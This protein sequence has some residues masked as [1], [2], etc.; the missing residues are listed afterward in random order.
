MCVC[1]IWEN[2]AD[3]RWSTS[4]QSPEHSTDHRNGIHPQ[5]NI[6]HHPRLSS[7][8]KLDFSQRIEE[9]YGF[10]IRIQLEVSASWAGTTKATS[11]ELVWKGKDRKESFTKLCFSHLNQYWLTVYWIACCSLGTNVKER[12][13]SQKLRATAA[14]TISR[15]TFLFNLTFP[16]YNYLNYLPSCNVYRIAS[17]QP[18]EWRRC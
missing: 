18:Y 15:K 9:R 7:K 2:Q 10:L 11:F 1:L 13:L 12:K 16:T 4:C 17:K 3:W 8:E 6:Q 14:G 5:S